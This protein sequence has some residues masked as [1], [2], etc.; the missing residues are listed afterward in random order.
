MKII[1]IIIFQMQLKYS[2]SLITTTTTAKTK[3]VCERAIEI[4]MA[5]ERCKYESH[6]TKRPRSSCYDRASIVISLLMHR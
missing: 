4:E 3:S 1:S 2:S 6:L 5:I